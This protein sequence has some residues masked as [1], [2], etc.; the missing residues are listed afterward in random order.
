MG[1]GIRAGC[2][3]RFVYAH[4]KGPYHI[5]PRIRLTSSK[6]APPG[7]SLPTL[8]LFA[9]I[10]AWSEATTNVRSSHRVD[11]AP[12][13]G[14]GYFGGSSSGAEECPRLSMTGVHHVMRHTNRSAQHGHAESV[15][16]HAIF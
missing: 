1:S 2:N 13:D 7:L 5:G 9:A 10:S 4:R 8:S 3:S 14:F 11:M 15:C 12:A 6:L 16:G